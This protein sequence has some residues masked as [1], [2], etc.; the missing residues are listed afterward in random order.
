MGCQLCGCCLGPVAHFQ[1]SLPGRPQHPKASRRFPKQLG[2][3]GPLDSPGVLVCRRG[4]GG[5]SKAPDPGGTCESLAVNPDLL[6]PFLALLW[7]HTMASHLPVLIT[8]Q[9]LAAPR[10]TCYPA[11]LLIT[12]S[13]LTFE[14]VRPQQWTAQYLAAGGSGWKEVSV[15][16]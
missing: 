4:S 1:M 12:S 10:S 2:C 15:C 6:G 3:L 7:C 11:W 8:C 9:T 14:A 5:S 13:C 16:G